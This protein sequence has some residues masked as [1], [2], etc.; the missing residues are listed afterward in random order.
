MV[1][2]TQ[3]LDTPSDFGSVEHLFSHLDVL[4]ATRTEYVQRS[5]PFVLFVHQHGFSCDSLLDFKRYL[6]TRN[7]VGVATKNKWL[8]TARIMLKEMHRLG[9]IPTDIT[10]NVKLFQHSKKH[11]KHGI[12]DNEMEL[13]LSYL[14]LLPTNP[15]TD[16]LKAVLSLLA[17]QGLR[18]IEVVRLRV[19]DIDL[20]AR[21]ALIQGKGRD[22][23]ELIDLHPLTVSALEKYLKSNLI[24]DGHLFVSVSNNSLGQPLTTRGLRLIVKLHLAKAGVQRHVHGFRHYFTT[25]LIENY[26]GNLLEV[27]KYTRHR[28]L[29]MLQVYNDAAKR[30]ADL[31]KYYETFY[32]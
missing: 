30:K 7:D 26:Q 31:P 4:D 23:K 15:Q 24:A 5:K 12:S 8:T 28:S 11:K 32:R 10:A 14:S 25:K 18:Q 27:A 19:A 13:L 22:D 29:E 1:E 6:R 16:R 9:Y 2:L 17:Y 3:I 21:T 20:I